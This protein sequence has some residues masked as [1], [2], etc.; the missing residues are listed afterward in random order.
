MDEQGPVFGMSERVDEI[1]AALV[2]FQSEVHDPHKTASN[3]FFS[4]KYVPLEDLLAA[5]RPVLNKHGIAL[6]QWRV[7]KGLVTMLL[8]SSGQYIFG[9]AEMLI[10]K[11]DPQGMGSATT[12][13]RRYSAS[14]ALGVASDPDDDAEKAMSRNKAP[15]APPAPAPSEPSAFDRASLALGKADSAHKL[16]A[17]WAKVLASSQISEEQKALLEPIKKNMEK[18]LG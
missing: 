16:E 5:V 14:S 8:H 15:E 2:A 17:V 9:H 12:Y 11:M 7:G 1:A 18:R 10:G 13:E 3:P 4:S 6:T